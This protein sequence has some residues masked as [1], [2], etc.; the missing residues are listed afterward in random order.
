MTTV[1]TTLWLGSALLFDGPVTV[2]WGSA[3][4]PEALQSLLSFTNSVLDVITNFLVAL[5]PVPILWVSP[6]RTSTK[7]VI[8]VLYT[9]IAAVVTAAAIRT[10]L[11]YNIWQTKDFDTSKSATMLSSAI[12]L[13]LGTLTA[14]LFTLKPLA[15]SLR[16]CFFSRGSKHFSTSSRSSPPRYPSHPCASTETVIHRPDAPH[17]LS[18]RFHDDESN[19]DFDIETPSIRTPTRTLRSRGTHSRNVSDWSQF[20]GF[21]YYTTTANS[22]HDASPRRSRV[23]S[24]NEMGLRTR[25]IGV[26]RAGVNDSNIGVAVT[27]LHDVP[28]RDSGGGEEM[29]ELARLFADNSKDWGTDASRSVRTSVATEGTRGSRHKHES[30]G[31]GRT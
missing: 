21:T 20:S 2:G 11:L 29:A 4:N 24:M 30:L 23:V 8:F 16:Q 12:E 18:L 19:L 7:L 31:D 25:S 26:G 14:C 9:L 28:V 15:S 10:Y 17:L 1:L 13:T 3:S 6:L 27:T 22:V 5:A